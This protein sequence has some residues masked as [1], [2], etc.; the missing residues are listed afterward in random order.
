MLKEV[1]IEMKEA[2]KITHHP[3]QKQKMYLGKPQYMKNL[4]R[5]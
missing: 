2:K 3:H 5:R 4:A 1:E